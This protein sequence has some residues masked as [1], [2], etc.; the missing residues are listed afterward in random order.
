[1]DAPDEIRRA[2]VTQSHCNQLQAMPLPPLRSIIPFVILSQDK[3]VLSVAKYQ[4]H[5]FYSFMKS[6]R[7]FVRAFAEVL[8]MFWKGKT[9]SFGLQNK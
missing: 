8:E 7:H 4:G 6:L 3:R 9:N 1:M 5:I 2:R